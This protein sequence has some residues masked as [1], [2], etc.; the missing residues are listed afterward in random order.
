MK[1][2][3]QLFLLIAFTGMLLTAC[4]GDDSDGDKVVTPVA[5]A[6]PTYHDDIAPLLYE[7]CVKC[8]KE[9]GIAPFSLL[10]DDTDG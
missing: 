1:N 2:L 4:G 5:V 10:Q 7:H 8:H 6:N 3:A 9:G